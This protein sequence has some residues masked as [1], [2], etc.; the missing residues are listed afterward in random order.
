MIKNDLNV[1]FELADKVHEFYI[2]RTVATDCSDGRVTGH[3][4]GIGRGSDARPFD[5][6]TGIQYT[7]APHVSGKGVNA[8]AGDTAVVQFD[9]LTGLVACSNRGPLVV[10]PCYDMSDYEYVDDYGP[11]RQTYRNPFVSRTGMPGLRGFMSS[12]GFE[13]ITSGTLGL[14]CDGSG[15]CCPGSAGSPALVA[16]KGRCPETKGSGTTAIAY[17]DSHTGISQCS[18]PNILVEEVKEGVTRLNCDDTNWFG[19]VKIR[20]RDENSEL[21]GTFQC[22]TARWGLNKGG[23]EPKHGG[24]LCA[25]D[26]AIGSFSTSNG[27]VVKCYGKKKGQAGFPGARG[28][29]DTTK[30]PKGPPGNNKDCSSHSCTCGNAYAC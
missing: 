27:L 22:S 18:N 26:E 19:V 9:S 5:G 28:E 3:F 30:G 1:S 15:G 16:F 12:H 2:N 6:Y 8:Y 29:D 24:Y 13:G 7:N 10:P 4:P 14:Q 20:G 23:V 17:F 25:G 11:L 21:V